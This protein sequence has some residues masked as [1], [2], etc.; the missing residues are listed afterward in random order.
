MTNY[1]DTDERVITCEDAA[2]LHCSNR[3]WSA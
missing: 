3:M 1:I 2:E